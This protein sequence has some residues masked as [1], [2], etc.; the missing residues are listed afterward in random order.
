MN[1]YDSALYNSMNNDLSFSIDDLQINNINTSL[2]NILLNIPIM[3]TLSSTISATTIEGSSTTL[4]LNGGDNT[5]NRFFW[6][7]APYDVRLDRIAVSL[8]QDDPT[9]D[10]INYNL[11]LDLYDN[12]TETIYNLG[13][14]TITTIITSD[15]IKMRT[16]FIDLNNDIIIKSG[17]GVRLKY[18]N[19]DECG[20][21]E[22]YVQLYNK[23][24]F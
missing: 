20:G 24:I 23:L 7:I 1:N 17:V 9:I 10:I 6:W 15:G 3:V 2:N 13:N 5:N 18:I 19:I 4:G 11:T 8:D 21:S 22:I 16:S 14:H 12:G